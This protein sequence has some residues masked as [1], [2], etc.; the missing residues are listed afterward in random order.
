MTLGKTFVFISSS[1]PREKSLLL[2]V[3]PVA[4]AMKW[5]WPPEAILLSLSPLYKLHFLPT[6]SFFLPT[7][8]F[9]LSPF[10]LDTIHITSAFSGVGSL[11]LLWSV[12]Y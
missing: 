8:H 12:V 2:V 1:A 10:L 9:G 7:P 3:F 5:K 6:T 11:F 4:M